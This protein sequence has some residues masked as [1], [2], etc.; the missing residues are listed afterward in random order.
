MSQVI[1]EDKYFSMVVWYDEDSRRDPKFIE[2]RLSKRH[3]GTK[4]ACRKSQKYWI[5]LAPNVLNRENVQRRVAVFCNVQ[6]RDLS[7]VVADIKT[8][9][10]PVEE[11]LRD[12]P[13]EYYLDYS[14]QFEAQQEP[15]Y[16]FGG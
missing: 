9:L 4:V 3:R 14:G 16:D 8:A 13:G 11:T 10:T 15:R 1:E 6:C 7:S 12:L 2:E 5:P